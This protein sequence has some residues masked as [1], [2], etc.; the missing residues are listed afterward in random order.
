M[1]KE[2]TDEPYLEETEVKVILREVLEELH[3]KAK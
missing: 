2:R 3:G 1:L